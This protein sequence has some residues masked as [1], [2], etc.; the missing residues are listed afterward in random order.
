MDSAPPAL[1][2][3]R[4]CDRCKKPIGPLEVHLRLTVEMLNSASTVQRYCGECCQD[5]SMAI[6]FADVLG[7]PVK[8]MEVFAVFR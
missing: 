6:L 1:L 4:N 5:S 2:Y 7:N 3:V 8:R